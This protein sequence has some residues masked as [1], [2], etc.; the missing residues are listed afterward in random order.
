M[1][2]KITTGYI[3]NI[4][5]YKKKITKLKDIKHIYLIILINTL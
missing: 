3:Q 2:K 1:K 4:F 5:I